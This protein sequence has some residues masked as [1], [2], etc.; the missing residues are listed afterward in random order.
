MK[1]ILR[2]Y[3]LFIV[4][5]WVASAAQAQD[6]KS[7]GVPY[8]QNYLKSEY[9]SGNQN[10]AVA[11]DAKG[12]MYFGNAEGL[13]T[14]DGGYWQLNKMPNKQIVRSVPR[15]MGRFMLEV[16]VNSAIGRCNQ[17]NSLIPHWFH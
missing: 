16:L 8:V 6:I 7:I 14:Y 9:L 13:L 10:W 12:V 3:F 15:V 1:F 4:F 2:N 5:L 17:E 11:K